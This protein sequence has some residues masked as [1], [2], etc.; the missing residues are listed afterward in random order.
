LRLWSAWAIALPLASSL[1]PLRPA[2]FPARALRSRRPLDTWFIALAT[3][4]LDTWFVAL[5]S[6]PL[7]L[8]FIALATEPVGESAALLVA[9]HLE[10]RTRILVRA[11][12]SPTRSASLAT[13]APRQRFARL[14]LRLPQA[15]A[16]K[17]HHHGVGMPGLQLLQ[18][19]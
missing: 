12:R 4:P 16:R 10:T 11:A 17:P 5:A 6:W 14:L 9:G 13:T 1:R 8:R 7:D 18:R 2:S 15:A 3:G 19:W